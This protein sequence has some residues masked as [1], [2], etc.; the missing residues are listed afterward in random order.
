MIQKQAFLP[1]AYDR[2]IAAALPFYEEYFKQITDAAGSAFHRPVAWLDVGCG[3]GKMAKQAMKDLEVERMV[4]CDPSPEML[5]LARE[6][7]GLYRADFLEM[8]VQ[9]LQFRSEF[10]VVT[11][12]LVNHY[13]SR[14]E[15]MTAVKNCCNALKTGGLFFTVENFAPNTKELRDLYLERWKNYQRRSGKSEAEC[16]EHL[17]RYNRAYFPVT[18]AEQM[19]IF[20]ECGFRSAEVFW[21]SCMQVGILG[22][23]G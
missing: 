1:E 10:D 3:T 7:V 16:R 4:C 11:A 15:R 20:R 6:R 9:D 8:R 22:I 14:E 12:V 19:R 13:L 5:E 23:K 17:L 18:I 2:D 21:C